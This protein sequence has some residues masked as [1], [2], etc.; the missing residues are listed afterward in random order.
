MPN[1]LEMRNITK[2]FPG[3]KAND[4]ISFE[5]RQGEVHAILGENGAGKSTLMSILFGIYQPDAGEI[6]LNNEQVTIK[7]PN[8]AYELG[9]GM[10]H[11]HFKLVQNFTVTENI[12]LGVEDLKNGF[13]STKKARDRI[14]ELSNLYNL[15]VDPDA[16][17]ADI[18]VGMQQ[19]V[20][21]LKVL[22]RNANILILDE[23]T[24]VLTPQQIDELMKIIK[25]FTE[26]GKSVIFISHKLDEIMTVANRCTV[27][28]R[29]KYIGTVDIANTNKNELSS[30]MVG[31]K[32]NLKVEKKEC[33]P[34]APVLEVKNLT[35]KLDKN[36]KPIL[37]DLTF[38][39]RAGE[40]VSIAGIDGN[41]QTE[42]VYALSG[43]ISDTT[44]SIKI[45]GK[46]I[47]GL[48]VRERTLSGLSHIPEDR[49][50]HG[51]VL[52]YSL[53]YNLVL[54][55]Y[56]KPQYQKHGV[57]KFAEITKNAE[58]LIQ[59]YDIRSG[60]GPKTITRS[61][62]GGN[63]QKAILAREISRS[64]DLLIACQP[65]RG[66]DVGAIEYIHQAIIAER[67]K[68]KAVLVVS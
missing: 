68:G 36:D 60:Q 65:T 42:L 29:G 27:L 28:K 34:G 15:D 46:E 44:G 11:Q 26:E 43:L 47:N 58:T 64:S 7:G 12:I 4:N 63:Q 66:L 9:L 56:F 24:A 33:T 1:V 53:E 25:K 57:L 62:S 22:Y 21:I 13:V 55:E 18:S 49:H 14:I 31:R 19:R 51:L 6:I 16:K 5:L 37:N 32:V 38:T 3:I 59:K 45:S 41:G 40:V 50:K 10:V 61:M 67:D 54:Q 39:V 23:P 8:H 20:E 48:S 17:I 30:M 2:S 52:D 35:Y